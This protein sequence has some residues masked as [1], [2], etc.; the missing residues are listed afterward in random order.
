VASSSETTTAS[1]DQPHCVTQQPVPGSTRLTPTPTP[2]LLSDASVLGLV[3]SV[4]DGGR[5]H[6]QRLP[7]Q[8]RARTEHL[9]AHDVNQQFDLKSGKI[10]D[11]YLSNNNNIVSSGCST[12]RQPDGGGRQTYLIVSRL[13]LIDVDFD[14][15]R[16]TKRIARLSRERSRCQIRIGKTGI[17]PVAELLHVEWEQEL[18]AEGQQQRQ[19]PALARHGQVGI[20]VTEDSNFDCTHG[21][22]YYW[23]RQRKSV[24]RSG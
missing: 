14:N 20:S 19:T 16:Y 13:Y 3:I 21:A 7:Q 17:A 24:I 23:E 22:K 10:I 11:N 2:Y 15:Y 5:S 9:F 8:I 6:V 18:R 4:L 1:A 12:G